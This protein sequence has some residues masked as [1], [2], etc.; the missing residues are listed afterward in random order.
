[1]TEDKNEKENIVH[2]AGFSDRRL[3]VEQVAEQLFLVWDRIESKFLIHSSD[4]WR[5]YVHEGTRYEPLPR[6]PWHTANSPAFYEN[7]EQLFN[8]IRSFLVDH[9]DV[10]NELLYDVYACFVLASWIPENFKIAPYLFF[11]GPL[12]SGKTRALECLNR[13]CYRAIMAASMSAAALFRALEAW[14]PTLLL[15]ESEVYNRKEMVEVLALLNSGYRKGQYAIRIEKIEEGNPVIA[16]FDTFGFKSIAGTEELAATLQSRC[17]ITPM[18]RAVRKVELFIDEERAQRL[19]DELLMYRFKNLGRF[20]NLAVTEFAIENGYYR[21]ARVL[22]LFVSLIQVA[23]TEEVKQRLFKCMNQITQSR[24]DAEQASLEARIFEAILKCE[25]QVENGKLSTQAI[26]AAFN[27]GIPEKEQLKS[28]QVG[29]RVAALGFE[30]CR[31][32]GG[33][34][35]FY[36]DAKLIERLKARY[37]PDTPSLPSQPSLPSLMMEKTE[38]SEPK[39]SE[40][41]EGSLSSPLC[42]EAQNTMK[43]EGSEQSE[44]SEGNSREYKHLQDTAF[45]SHI[46]TSERCYNG[47]ALIAEWQIKIGND[48]QQLFCNT[49]FEK[50]KRNLEQNSYEVKYKEPS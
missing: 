44:G 29:R 46:K 32:S 45:V 43:S 27:E 35:G 37:Y 11:L 8:E 47:C 13:L 15:D 18:S 49:C 20:E 42:Q 19:R 14:H 50:A 24:L 6:L 21:N 16:M 22:E 17:I 40:V 9:L 48:F 28:Y 12:A 38:S 7:E 30:K 23:P 10:S 5:Y 34:S 33:K 1:M 4:P 3:I 25:S 36:W 31:F 39:P 26:T 2:C 41:S